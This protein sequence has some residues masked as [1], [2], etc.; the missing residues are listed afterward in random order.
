MS[1]LKTIQNRIDKNVKHRQKWAKREGLEAYRIY[2]KDIPEFPFIVDYYNGHAVIFEKRDEEID[3]DK[4]DH[5]NF[6]ISAVKT[7]LNLPEE[8]I[9]IKS[10][11]R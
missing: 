9:I 1:D 10:R 5:F 8:K 3:A 7:I 11:F 2:E 6:I 4:F